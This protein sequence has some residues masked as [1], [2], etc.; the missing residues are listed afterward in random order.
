MFHKLSLNSS[1]LWD[2]TYC[3]LVKNRHFRTTYRSH[4]QGCSVVLNTSLLKI[5]PIGSPKTSVLNQLH[6][7]PEDGRIQSVF[8]VISFWLPCF[9]NRLSFN[10]I[11]FFK[12][13]VKCENVFINSLYYCGC[14]MFIQVGFSACDAVT[15]LKM[16]DAGFPK[17]KL[18]LMAIPLVPLQI[19][20]PLVISKRI[21]G[22]RPLNVYI[23]AYPYR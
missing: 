19:I 8:D 23:S 1:V 10:F 18:A 11:I 7:V 13:N 5:R 20:L 17:E 14:L 9:C 16:I 3:R 6:N 21:V 15:S 22:A 4:L 2:V 12:I